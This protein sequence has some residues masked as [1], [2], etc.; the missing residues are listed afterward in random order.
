MKRL[1]KIYEL[2]K[3]LLKSEGQQLKEKLQ[4]RPLKP[5]IHPHRTQLPTVDYETRCF[6]EQFRNFELDGY[7]PGLSKE[8][9]TLTQTAL[10]KLISSRSYRTEFPMA[11][12]H[13]CMASKSNMS[14]NPDR[15]SQN[16]MAAMG[17]L[18]NDLRDLEGKNGEDVIKACM[19]WRELRLSQG[20]RLVTDNWHKRFYWA[21]SGGSHHMAVL[22]HELLEQ[23]RSWDPEVEICEY[24][25]NLGC[26]DK[27]TN[28][29]SIIVVMRDEELFGGDQI[30]Q[31]LPK[32]LSHEDIRV[33]LGVSVPM[34]SHYRSPFRDYQMVLVDHS[35]R[36]SDLAWAHLKDAVDNGVALHFKDFLTAW[37]S[38][39]A[40]QL[41]MPE[42][43]PV[44]P[45]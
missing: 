3:W 18:V 1:I 13:G 12:L 9:W 16:S 29:V 30:F 26:L 33:G 37:V 32:T 14:T 8:N 17:R 27:L 40:S 2:T 43:T 39:K 11:F 10:N 44:S 45:S 35:Q 15:A 24:S 5:F 25:L 21:N 31:R 20:I 6:L 28:H 41:S 36:H 23:N 7:L 22:C 34:P 42:H 19:A 38:P 4:L